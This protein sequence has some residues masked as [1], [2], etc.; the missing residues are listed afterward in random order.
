[1]VLW[2]INCQNLIIIINCYLATNPHRFILIFF[3]PLFNF[4]K[5]KQYR[6]GLLYSLMH[7]S[8]RERNSVANI[9]GISCSSLGLLY[10]PLWWA[11]SEAGFPQLRAMSHPGMRISSLTK[12]HRHQRTRWV[13]VCGHGRSAK[14][15]QTEGCAAMGRTR[16][17][18]LF[19]ANGVQ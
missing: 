15:G 2:W 8:F 4:H 17:D 7:I 1:M 12:A 18:D 13:C 6:F 5:V 16:L 9:T 10:L 14:D 19:L 11:G 3:L